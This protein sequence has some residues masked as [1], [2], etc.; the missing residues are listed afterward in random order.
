MSKRHIRSDFINEEELLIEG[1]PTL[2]IEPKDGH[3]PMGTVIIYHGWS[4]C[5]A[6]QRIRA[7]VLAGFGYRVLVPDSIY[8]GERDPLDNYSI[9]NAG[10]YIW[11]V[12]LQTIEEA[13]A[14]INYT[15]NELR[16]KENMLAV[17]GNSMGGFA[18]SAIFAHNPEIRSGVICSSSCHWGRSNELFLKNA[19][20]YQLDN[21]VLDKDK[22]EK[23]DPINNLELF[24]NR[25][26]LM[27]NGEADTV[28]SIE[29]QE[30]F[31][32]KAKLYYADPSHLKFIKYPNLDHFVTTN[33]MEE[34][35]IWLGTH[36][37]GN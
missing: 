27:L 28:V 3:R 4:S 10:K 7:Y 9:E 20:Y 15:F 18:A 37:V 36:M 24:D 6:Y 1:I 23:L 2:L 11:K 34:I 19:E 25:P 17:L 16:E 32:E 30:S 13:P 12:I 35:I 8:H 29:G 33:M 14:L 21:F 22:I 31:Y 26:L 5:K